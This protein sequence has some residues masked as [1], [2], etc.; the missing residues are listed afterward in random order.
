MKNKSVILTQKGFTLLELMS[1]LI[2]MGV[3][4]S[5][6]V[7]KLDLISDTASIYAIEA[8]VRELNTRETLVWT[9]MKLS[10]TDWSNDNDVYAAVD[11]NLGQGYAWNPPGPSISAG[12]LNYKSQTVDLRRTASTKNSVGSWH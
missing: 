11:T 4:T 2:I 9:Q 12:T 8:G 7:K 1:V 6:S 10:E 5:L 3:M